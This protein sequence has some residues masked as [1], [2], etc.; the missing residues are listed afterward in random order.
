M[1]FVLAQF[2]KMTAQL[3]EQRRWLEVSQRLAAWQDVARAM[4]HELKNPLTAMKMALGR[5]ARVDPSAR[6]EADRAR[7]TESI[8]LLEE[9]VDALMRMTQSFSDFAKLPAASRKPV[10]LKPLLEEVA[11]LYAQQASTGVQVVDAA[12]LELQ[13][14]PDQL[15]RVLSNLVKNAIEA[16]A[17][18]AEP[19]KLSAQQ[20]GDRAVITVRDHGHG[21]SGPLAMGQF[22]EGISQ[23]PGGS[24]LGLPITQKIVHEHGGTLR[25]EPAPDRGTLATVEL[26]L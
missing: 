23:K 16:S 11:A 22:V 2:N 8:S 21:L 15:R 26:P 9:Q 6:A 4:A 12:D 14:D 5:I 18:T 3:S 10:R 1:G 20:R 17:D 19:V 25:L 24:G 7:M 13:A